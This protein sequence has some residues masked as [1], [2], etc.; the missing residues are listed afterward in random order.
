M[1]TTSSSTPRS[2]FPGDSE[3]GE[4]SSC[5]GLVDD[6]AGASRRMAT[7]PPAHASASV[8]R[9]PFPIVLWWGADFTILYNDAYRPSSGSRASALLGRPGP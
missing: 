8:S 1:S 2:V 6:V 7:E 5:P 3:R 4:S 9:R